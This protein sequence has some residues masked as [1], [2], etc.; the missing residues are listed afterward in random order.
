MGKRGRQ[1]LPS[2]E[3]K[4]RGSWRATGRAESEMPAPLGQPP[5]PRWIDR[6]A[7]TLYKTLSRELDRSGVLSTIDQGALG[8]YCELFSLWRDAALDV[9][10]RG[11]I[12]EV[13]IIDRAGEIVGYNRI[14]NPSVKQ[15]QNYSAELLRLENNFGL[16]PSA[17]VGMA[18][19]KPEKPANP[20]TE[21]AAKL[22]EI[23]KK[24][25]AA[26]PCD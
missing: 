5:M 25:A 21:F 22:A 17:R 18:I 13:P 6:K 16:T 2:A 8:R 19:H 26:G 7:Q 9:R 1:P 11:Q 12:F 14:P 20:L 3:L 23:K 24:R 10:Q 15:L 4:R